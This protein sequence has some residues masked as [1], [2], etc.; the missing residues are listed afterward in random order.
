MDQ[1]FHSDQALN[2]KMEA[3]ERKKKENTKNK[4]EKECKN[5]R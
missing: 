2:D 4:T 1:N 5:K 3:K